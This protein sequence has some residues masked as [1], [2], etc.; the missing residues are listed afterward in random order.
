MLVIGESLNTTRK[1]VKEAVKNQDRGFVQRLAVEQVEAG[2]AMLDVNA[3]VAGRSEVEDLPWMV[4]A[5]QEVVDVPL[6][7]DSS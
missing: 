2:A 4:Q 6:A 7:L 1:D 3:A 5:V